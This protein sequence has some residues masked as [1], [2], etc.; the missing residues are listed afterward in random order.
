VRLDK[1][2]GGKASSPQPLGY[3]GAVPPGA[4]SSSRL[5][6]WTSGKEMRFYIN[7]EYQFTVNDPSLTRGGLGVFIR[8][9]GDDAVTVSFSDLEV[10]EPVE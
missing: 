9:N 6:V 1:Y 5:G 3:S 7:G 10:Y 4:P 8:S 2:F